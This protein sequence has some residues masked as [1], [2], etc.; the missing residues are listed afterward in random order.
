MPT[1]LKWGA[2]VSIALLQAAASAAP[3]TLVSNGQPRARIVV[4]DNAVP[5]V[6]YAAEELQYHIRKATGA[7]L[8][9]VSE[10]R[11]D[12][13]LPHRVFLGD[14]QATRK[15]G[16]AFPGQADPAEEYARN[17]RVKWGLRTVS[18]DLFLAGSDNDGAPGDRYR[19]TR[20][21]TLFAV[22]EFLDREMGVRWLWPSEL[23]EVIPPR[24]DLTVGPLDIAGQERLAEA[25]YGFKW[26]L[27]ANKNRWY[28]EAHFKAFAEAQSK[29]LLR[30]RMGVRNSVTYSYGHYFHSVGEYTKRFLETRPDF[31]QRLP[32]GKRGYI[33]GMSGH[34]ISMCVG[35]PDLRKQMIEDWL[36]YR[37]EDELVL[38]GGKIGGGKGWMLNACENDT[39]AG[40]TCPQCRALDA[41]D[42]RFLNHDYWSGGVLVTDASLLT[43]PSKSNP[44]YGKVR[45]QA[46]LPD[47]K[48]RP[49]PS[50]SDRYAR[51]YL[52]LQK[53]AEKSVPGAVVFGYAYS[54]YVLPPVETKLNDHIVISMVPWPYYPWT[55][56]DVTK[57]KATWEQW[58]ATGARLV[59]R[60]NTMLTGH[61]FSI[62]MARRIGE[63]FAHHVRNGAV[64]TAFDSL[65]SQWASKGPDHYVLARM[66]AHPDWPVDKV[67]DE[68]YAGFGKASDAVRKYF[69]HWERVS[70]TAAKNPPA[71]AKTDADDASEGGGWAGFRQFVQFAPHIFPPDAMAQGR[72]LIAQAQKAAAGDSLA[73]RR[74]AFLEKGLTHAQLTLDVAKAQ[75]A[76]ASD[77][78]NPQKR[79][80]LASAMAKLMDYRRDVVEPGMLANVGFLAALEASP[81]GWNHA[82]ERPSQP[83]TSA[84]SPDAN[85]GFEQATPGQYSVSAPNGNSG[86]RPHTGLS[87]WALVAA[88]GQKDGA[89]S[90]IEGGAPEGARYYRT[91]SF[92]PFLQRQ[93]ETTPGRTCKVTFQMRVDGAE[94]DTLAVWWNGARVIVPGSKEWKE[95]TLTFKGTGKDTLKF[96]RTKKSHPCLDAIRVEIVQEGI[97]K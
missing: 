49:A 19:G 80:A 3:L 28:S 56:A 45:Y 52:A 75:Q 14:C 17:E 9:I 13:A 77:A 64:A 33:P 72:A 32:N 12:S 58:H 67:L 31:F 93:I 95:Y 7:Q 18:Q 22:Y 76:L 29:W 54:N 20:H 16:I 38:R 25:E 78:E 87:P 44:A 59:L 53:E 97:T 55:D 85:W 48:G 71:S 66:H 92:S 86:N 30:Q 65:T 43:N 1:R 21:G 4:P 6:K 83:E 79:D 5:V 73:E 82:I 37:K 11:A 69:E 40:C 35:N 94:L 50:L 81:N 2:A 10:A 24:A 90:I 96:Q 61:N 88:P 63:V 84:Q 34:I 68:Y 15:A 70:E 60:P 26:A 62:F 39:C 8:E 51:F 47:A 46:A 89:V 42:P 41:K 91:V 27:I 57:M 36:G 23:G 74:V